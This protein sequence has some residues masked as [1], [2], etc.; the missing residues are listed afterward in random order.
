MRKQVLLLVSI[1][2]FI[3]LFA[4]CT[5]TTPVPSD[6]VNLHVED[7]KP[8]ENEEH[9]VEPTLDS[10]EAPTQATE[11]DPYAELETVQYASQ[12][13][14]SLCQNGESNDSSPL[15]TEEY[16]I[17]GSDEDA[18]ILPM[19]RKQITID[20]EGSIGT[21]EYSCCKFEDT[22]YTWIIGSENCSVFQSTHYLVVQ[23][24]EPYWYFY[25]LETGILHDAMKDL[26]LA[27][28]PQ[29]VLYE[30]SGH[31]MLLNRSGVLL[32]LFD[33]SDD[34][35]IYLPMKDGATTVYGSFIDDD[36][37]LIQYYL[38]DDIY[39]AKYCISTG[40]LTE[41]DGVYQNDDSSQDNFLRY[42]Q[43]GTI[44]YTF[45]DG[46]LTLWDIETGEK[47]GTGLLGDSDNYVYSY[48]SYLYTV[49]DGIC[50]QLDFSGQ[51]TPVCKVEK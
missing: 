33:Y 48:G 17:F 32:I 6:D 20:S 27:I 18:Q 25:D 4:G 14:E 42:T 29:S 1:I 10:T 41:Y 40:E 13:F 36:N 8:T 46:E 16:C 43:V 37:I 31:F 19:E 7:T 39:L 23:F 24:A 47:A 30:F 26:D 51:A 12:Y 21:V 45:V 3:C 22:W 2:L 38:Y 50:Y 5:S 34:S 28:G 35:F 9:T 44:L 49:M 11:A 15:V